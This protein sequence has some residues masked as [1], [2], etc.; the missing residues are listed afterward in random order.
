MQICFKRRGGE[1]GAFGK[2][3]STAAV[4]TLVL[5]VVM[6]VA[7]LAMPAPRALASDDYDRWYVVELD[8]KR[9]GWLNLVQ[10]T[11][12]DRITTKSAMRFEAG[13]GNAAVIAVTMEGEFVETVKGEPVSMRVS[14]AMG[15]QPSVATYTYGPEGVKVRVA[16]PGAPETEVTRPLPE[17]AWLT[18]AAAE[19]YIAQR[20]AAKAE[21]IKVRRVD[22][23][24]GAMNPS[25]ADRPIT[26]TLKAFSLTTVEVMGKVVPAIRCLSTTS[27]APGIETQQYIDEHGVPIR[28]DAKLGAMTVATLL[29][30]K[31]VAL[32]KISP[33]EIM[34][35]SFVKPTGTIT[36][37]RS[38]KRASYL[39]SLPD[40]SLPDLPATGSQR[41]E[42]VDGRTERVRVDTVNLALAD[43]GDREKA[44][45]RARSSMIDGEDPKV[46][47]LAARAV[48]GAGPNATGRAE[49]MRRFVYTYI[50]EK[51]LGV[52]FAS[53][54]EVARTCTG[55]C[56]E[57]GVLLAA[58]LRAEGI[59]SRV[60]SGLIYADQFAGSKGIFGYHMWAQALL[61]VDGGWAWV[62]VDGTL[63][64]GV[65]TDATHIAISVSGLADGETVSSMAVLAPLLG[66]IQIK[67]EP[68]EEI[69]K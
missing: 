8:G 39:V 47:E 48:D 61:Q 34:A 26:E 69:A 60:A 64:P 65:P 41:V 7:V 45:Y 32:A 10:L 27:A 18:P 59:P 28:T 19:R 57:H 21:E 11:E 3:L 17:G 63:P 40:G 24:S 62:D 29:S 12:A 38:M 55:D 46:R 5:W 15:S 37:P 9:A 4:R 14:M 43:P 25:G 58:M 54:S 22:P 30:E 66:R 16:A 36:N 68:A 35:S 44:E 2:T 31:D 50:K 56:T 23:G 53:A 52:G 51:S 20:I 42:R 49:A 1:G 6:T 13:R 33:P 67:V